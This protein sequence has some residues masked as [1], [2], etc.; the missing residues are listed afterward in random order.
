M[1]SLSW[2][3]G[4]EIEL[5]APRGKS[6]ED[7]A[8]EIAKRA[9]GSVARCLYP[10]SEPSK[11][12]G[13]PV[14]EN[15]ILGFDVVDQNGNPL[16]KCVD[17]ITI[18]ADLHRNAPA[19][20]HWYRIVSDEVRMLRLVVAQCDA[21]ADYQNVLDPIA[22][23]FGTEPDR[24]QGE[25]VRVADQMNAPVAL[26]ATLPGERERPCELITPPL[27][28][29]HLEH[30]ESLLDAAKDL[31]F[32]VPREAAVHI[33]FDAKKLQ[34]TKVFARLVQVFG[35]F[36]PEIRKL[37]KPNPA[38]VRLGPLSKAILKRVRKSDF[39]DLDWDTAKE[40]ILELKP[41]KYCDY[42]VLNL[43]QNIPGKTTLEI[44]I[45]PGSMDAEEI[46]RTARFFEAILNW[47]VDSAK[48]T[49]PPRK[50]GHFLEELILPQ[51]DKACWQAML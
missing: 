40:A 35:D 7:L 3:T 29:N 45:L 1:T 39:A 12:P 15:L 9:G 30:L 20:P 50:L 37:V 2:K 47:C 36:G 31:E 21:N 17:D 10:Q 18:Q 13:T 11:V 28:Q 4:F 23:L 19:K 26:A 22:K 49:K 6:R 5:L 51:T 44:R 33:H 27:E 24:S 43:L 25:L 8:K 32:S 48:H 14:F 16:A 38:C 41:T 42:N 46:I 34:Q